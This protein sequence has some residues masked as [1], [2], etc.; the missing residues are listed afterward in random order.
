VPS[1]RCVEPSAGLFPHPH[2]GLDLDRQR[3]EIKLTL[4]LQVAIGAQGHQVFRHVTALLVSLNFVM[5]L[6]VLQ[7][8]GLPTSLAVT[9]RNSLQTGVN[10]LREPGAEAMAAL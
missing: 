4:L 9:L 1:D 6:K 3:S 10:L 7:R 5:D 8:V 2:L